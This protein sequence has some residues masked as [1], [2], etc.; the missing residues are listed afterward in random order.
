[1]CHAVFT[2][3]PYCMDSFISSTG[4]I[5]HVHGSSRPAWWLLWSAWKPLGF[6]RGKQTSRILSEVCRRYFVGRETKQ[7]EKWA[8]ELYCCSVQI[9]GHHQNPGLRVSLHPYL[10]MGPWELSG[11]LCAAGQRHST[12]LQ[13]LARMQILRKAH[14]DA[15]DTVT[16]TCSRLPQRSDTTSD[17]QSVNW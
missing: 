17:A 14:R 13:H 8:A 2:S 9:P 11:R 3:Q 12:F 10:L 1:M 5:S 6:G 16:L 4:S 15:E 7:D